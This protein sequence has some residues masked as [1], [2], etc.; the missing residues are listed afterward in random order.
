MIE[1]TTAQLVVN[2]LKA[3]GWTIR[4][5]EGSDSR[6]A[7]HDLVV[8][9]PNR[10]VYL[11]ELKG[12]EEP[13][14]FATIAQAEQNAR[15]LSEDGESPV[16]PVL[17]TSQDVRP[18]L[19]GLARDVGVRVVQATGSDQEAADSVVQF[20]TRNDSVLVAR[21][22]EDLPTPWC[23]S[24]SSK[25]EHPPGSIP[26][27]AAYT[28]CAPAAAHTRPRKPRAADACDSRQCVSRAA[29]AHAGRG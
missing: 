12:G 8:S 17:A 23:S 21:P 26:A 22:G 7:R 25:V 2:A 13:M 20:L 4:R 18:S 19:S 11:I 27:T 16:T 29:T 3:L 9:D 15:Q 6:S 10:K 1:L 14:H 28:D 5:G 24:S